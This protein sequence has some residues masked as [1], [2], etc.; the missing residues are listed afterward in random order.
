MQG[1]HHKRRHRQGGGNGGG[2]PRQLEQREHH[3]HKHRGHQRQGHRRQPGPH[4]QGEHQQCPAQVHDLPVALA[5]ADGLA[6][7]HRRGSA[8][9]EAHHQE[10]PVQVAH[11]GVGRQHLHGVVGIAQ[12]HRQQ[13]VAQAP[14][15]L[16]E[17]HR[18]GVFYE[19]PQHLPPRPEEGGQVQG[20]NAAAQGA[21]QADE[22]L[23]HPGQQRGD[24]RALDAQGRQA[25]FAEDQQIVHPGVQQGGH[26]EQLHAE[27]GILGAAHGAD[28]DGREH[29]E[30]IGK[31]DELQIRRAQHRQLMLV[32]QQVHDLHRP[33]KQ[34]QRQ[35][36]G[37]PR[38]QHGRH[39]DGPADALHVLFAPV[40]AHQ[41]AQAALDAEHDGDQQKHRH[42][43]GGHGGHLGVAQP[44]DHQRV[45]EAQR[46]GN[47][48]LQGNGPRQ[49]PQIPVEARSS[50]QIFQHMSPH[51]IG[52]R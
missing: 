22:K 40:L 39:A 17:D 50:F 31:A 34:H 49:P 10:Q 47:Q 12:D 1:D 46:E 42:V 5:L 16:V 7:H 33:Q 52:K 35:H 38:A 20:Q 3:R 37:D 14:G 28:I 44:A 9:A 26:A 29:I 18:G 45:D 4:Q 41:D 19:A 2:L 11:H 32:G 48:I 43:G 23:R 27:A 15:G 25:A 8:Q 36:Q 13:A 6:D 24:G 21:H 51:S 30:H